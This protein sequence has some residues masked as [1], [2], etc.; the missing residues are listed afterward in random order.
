[1]PLEKYH[2]LSRGVFEV[3]KVTVASGQYFQEIPFYGPPRAVGEG[4]PL[5][6]TK[7]Y[8]WKIIDCPRV[9]LV[10]SNHLCYL[11]YCSSN[12]LSYI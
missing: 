10:Y 2:L 12:A 4:Q 11:L 7:F 1:M 6:I 3:G 9:S 8:E 5:E